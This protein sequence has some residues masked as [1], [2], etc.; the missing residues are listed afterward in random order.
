MHRCII[1]S[2]NNPVLVTEYAH[3]GDGKAELIEMERTGLSGCRYTVQ[4]DGETGTKLAIDM[5]IKNNPLLLA[6][7]NLFMKNKL[8]NKL[9]KSISNLGAYCQQLLSQTEANQQ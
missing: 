2:K 6:F 9:T 1:D 4:P 5:L 8:R 3:I 7:F